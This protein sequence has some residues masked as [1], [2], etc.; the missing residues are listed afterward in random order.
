VEN[1]RGGVIFYSLGNLVFDQMH[2]RDTQRGL[3]A[4]VIF[5][6]ARLERWTAHP[7]EIR[8]VV[9]ELSAGVRASGG[10]AARTP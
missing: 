10:T 9:P 3:V 7:V 4:E 8:G 1:Y 5:R 2:R 6:G